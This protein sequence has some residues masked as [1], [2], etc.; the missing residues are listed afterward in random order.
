MLFIITPDDIKVLK[1]SFIPLLDYTN[2]LEL[3]WEPYISLFC[4]AKP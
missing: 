1:T 2:F 3:F 4:Q